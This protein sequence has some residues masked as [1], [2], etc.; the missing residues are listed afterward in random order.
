M[1]IF[2]FV[3]WIIDCSSFIRHPWQNTK[4]IKWS[5]KVVHKKQY[6]TCIYPYHIYC[7]ELQCIPIIMYACPGCLNFFQPI[8]CITPQAIL[9]LVLIYGIAP[10]SVKETRMTKSCIN[11]LKHTVSL[12]QNEDIRTR[13]TPRG[14]HCRYGSWIQVIVQTHTIYKTRTIV[15]D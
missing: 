15:L 7:K 5:S 4:H 11:T 14:M 13:C 2:N 3:K 12:T 10:V 6:H 1:W 8:S 9:P